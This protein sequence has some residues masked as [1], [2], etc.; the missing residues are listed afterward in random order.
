LLLVLVPT[1]GAQSLGDT[2]MLVL[3]MIAILASELQTP[4]DWQ[5][6]GGAMV[7]VVLLAGACG[8]LVPARLSACTATTVTQRGHMGA[9]CW[10]LAGCGIRLAVADVATANGGFWDSVALEHGS[11]CAVA[12]VVAGV[13]GE[14]GKCG[15][16]VV[17]P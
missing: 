4:R 8:T 17:S 6:A 3:V 12:M 15:A 16:D 7:A 9:Q 2:D 13:G 11:E 14:W 1:P 10:Y 5:V